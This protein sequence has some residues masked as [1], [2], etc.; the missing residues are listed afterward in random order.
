MTR[1]GQAKGN[2]QLLDGTAQ[3]MAA[4]LGV[5]WRP[6]LMRATTPEA[7]QYQRALGNAYYQEGL[8]KTGNHYDAARYYHGGP[9]RRLWGPKTNAYAQAVVARM[10]G[11][12]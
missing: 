1:W 7:A 5:D 12:Q 4:K 11:Q 10:S 6:D 9:D 2:M 8:E 3:G